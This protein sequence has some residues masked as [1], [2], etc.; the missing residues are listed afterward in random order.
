[1]VRDTRKDVLLNYPVGK[2]GNANKN[3][4]KVSPFPKWNGCQSKKKKSTGKGC[5]DK[6]P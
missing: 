3:Q 2:C 6:V 4:N 5:G 1:M